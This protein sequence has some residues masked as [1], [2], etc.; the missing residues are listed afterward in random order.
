ME[1]IFSK[2]K[3]RLKGVE[4]EKQRSQ[5]HRLYLQTKLEKHV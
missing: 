1:I 2:E 3:Q 5:E 4:F